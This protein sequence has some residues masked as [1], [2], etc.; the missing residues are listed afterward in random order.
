MEVRIRS[1]EAF[2]L[3]GCKLRMS[4]STD[5]TPQLWKEFMPRRNQIL[6][7]TGTH[8][9]SVQVFD[10]LDYF[11]TNKP[12][13]TFE[14]WAAMRSESKDFIPTKMESCE[15]PKGEYAVFSYQGKPSEAFEAFEHIFEVWVPK[16]IYTLDNRPHF[17]LMGEKYLGEDPRSEEEIWIPIRLK[18]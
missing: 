17:T 3:I 6:K 11:K 16:S 2:I 14:K 8:F 18:P 7:Q 4:I 15:I 10:N 5:Q 12:N 1:V 9:Y 13:K